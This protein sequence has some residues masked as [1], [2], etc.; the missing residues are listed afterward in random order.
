VPIVNQ[1]LQAHW[2]RAASRGVVA[3]QA[4]GGFGKTTAAGWWAERLGQPVVWLRAEYAPDLRHVPAFWQ[5]LGRA[6][7]DAAGDAQPLQGRL[8]AEDVAR[9]MR[10]AFPAG[11]SLILDDYHLIRSE[12]LDAAVGELI[13]RLPPESRLLL[14]T[15]EALTLPGW[16]NRLARREALLLTDRDLVF[17]PTEVALLLDLPPAAAEIVAEQTQGWVFALQL[18]QEAR[19]YGC[20]AWDQEQHGQLASYLFDEIL[21]RVPADVVTFM[22]QTAWMEGFTLA[23]C[24]ALG[25]TGA[26]HL[27][28]HIVRDRLFVIQDGEHHH[29]HSLVREALR[30]HLPL[31]ERQAWLGRLAAFYLARH[32]E[33]AIAAFLHAGD[34]AGAAKAVAW[35]ALAVWRE[36]PSHQPMLDYWMARLPGERLQDD[37]WYLILY[38]LQR[39]RAD[40][41]DMVTA[42]F[43]AAG[44]TLS[45]LGDRAGTAAA[46]YCRARH[47]WHSGDFATFQS[48]LPALDAAR[49]ALPPHH[50]FGLN[51]LDLSLSYCVNAVPDRERW[52]ALATELLALPP[53]SALVRTLHYR[54]HLSASFLHASWGEF[55]EAIRHW[56]AAARLTGPTLKERLTMGSNQAILANLLPCDP[57]LPES[58]LLDGRDMDLASPFERL[59]V[60]TGMTDHAWARA[61]WAEAGHWLQATLALADEGLTFHHQTTF[62][63]TRLRLGV[64]ALW[65]GDQAEAR[66]CIDQAAAENQSDLIA[67][68]VAFHQAWCAWRQGRPAEARQAAERALADAARWDQKF[69]IA[70]TLLLRALIDDQPAG[71]QACHLVARWE[72]R[73]ALTRLFPEA[74]PLLD[75]AARSPV[76]GLL[77]PD[78]PVAIYSLGGLR[79]EV[80]GRPVCWKRANAQLI[81]LDLLLHPEGSTGEELLERYWPLGNPGLRKDVQT[82]REALEPGKPAQDS[83]YVRLDGRRRHWTREAALYWWD[84]AAFETLCDLA[85]TGASPECRREAAAGARD[86]YRGDFVP[87]WSCVPVLEPA[88][89]RLR[90][91]YLGLG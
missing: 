20:T 54:H 70:K 64:L 73:H 5:A 52:S 66:R 33:T 53:A 39:R 55:R 75:A 57:V 91:R 9:L 21:S 16:Q 72:Y 44:T 81:L 43:L 77:C 67:A 19:R 29:Y 13:Q 63:E 84:V 62:T 15:R 78:A 87:E 65:R 47:H 58:W 24:E 49:A 32:R 12:A 89:Q 27:L 34:G 76:P 50:P 69:V 23:E 42:T 30:Q 80:D 17:T 79:V 10:T 40:A 71:S 82:L 14:T 56:Q 60:T 28:R 26:D 6:L 90:Q 41:P 1:R 8:E 7:L 51:I 68:E 31:A 61:D 3:L 59:M 85:E 35:F 88:R 48:L 45:R 18:L 37:G 83:C 38:G 74:L 11:C 25:L 46:L 86:L 4:P 36:I 22:S 2:T